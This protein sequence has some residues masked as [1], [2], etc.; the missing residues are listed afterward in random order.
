[1][2]EAIT[3]KDLCAFSCSSTWQVSK[4]SCIDIGTLKGKNELSNSSDPSLQSLGDVIHYNSRWYFDLISHDNQV[5]FRI[6][7]N[8]VLF[9]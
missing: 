3:S 8:H 1:M 2:S 9:Y 5:S 4:L 7:M 6:L